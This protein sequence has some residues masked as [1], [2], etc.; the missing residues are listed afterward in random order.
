MAPHTR[1]PWCRPADAA[2]A[3]HRPLQLSL[4]AGGLR[5]D[6]PVPRCAEAIGAETPERDERS[7]TRAGRVRSRTLLQPPLSRNASSSPRTRT[8]TRP[9]PCGTAPTIAGRQP[10]SRPRAWPTSSPALRFGRERGLRIAVR[11]GGHNVAGNGPVEGGLV[12]H[13]GALKS[14]QVDPARQRVRIEP[15]VVL[16]D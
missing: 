10:S 1:L 6:D 9:G 14:V 3:P 16:G 2:V 7:L 13:L 12:I 5:W 4:V 8:T 15:G 11:S